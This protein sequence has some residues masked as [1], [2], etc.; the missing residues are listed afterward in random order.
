MWSGFVL[1]CLFDRGEHGNM[2]EERHLT[3]SQGLRDDFLKDNT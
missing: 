3:I 1:F 2:P